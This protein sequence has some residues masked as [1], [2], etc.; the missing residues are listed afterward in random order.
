[1]SLAESPDVCEQEESAR[2]SIPPRIAAE[3]PILAGTAEQCSQ[4]SPRDAY[5]RRDQRGIHSANLTATTDPL[6]LEGTV[7]ALAPRVGEHSTKSRVPAADRVRGSRG[8]G[9]RQCSNELMFRFRVEGEGGGTLR[10]ALDPVVKVG[11]S[12]LPLEDPGPL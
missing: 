7:T 1:V 11:D 6:G 5:Q 4:Q 12:S 3:R 2:A 10:S 9:G 8:A